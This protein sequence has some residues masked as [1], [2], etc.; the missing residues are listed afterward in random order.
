MRRKSSI[1]LSFLL[2]VL[3]S[4]SYGFTDDTGIALQGKFV[5]QDEG[6]MWFAVDGNAYLSANFYLDFGTFKVPEKFPHRLAFDSEKQRYVADGFVS[7]HWSFSRDESWDCRYPVHFSGDADP[8]KRFIDVTI[9]HQT[10]L[11]TPTRFGACP[12]GPM[13][14]DYYVFIKET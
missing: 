5:E 4:L 1:L 9:E 8:T 11:I 7:V 10:Y 6:A 12:L 14:E 2:C 13:T 3:A